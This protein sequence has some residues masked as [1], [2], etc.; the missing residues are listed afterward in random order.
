MDPT[1][2][3]RQRFARAIAAGA[4][5]AHT[6][7]ALLILLIV[8]VSYLAL[9]PK[10]PVSIDF[11]WDKLNH[12]LAFTALAFSAS[13]GYPASRGMRLLLLCGLLAFGGLIEALQLFVPGRSS[14]W[15]DLLGDSIG[16]ASGAI[17]ADYVLRAASTLSMRSLE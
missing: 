17:I 15:G 10:P 4:A 2:G 5:A 7:R 6:W 12:V 16:V 11:G 3:L 8:A 1:S 13:L 9:T 14:E